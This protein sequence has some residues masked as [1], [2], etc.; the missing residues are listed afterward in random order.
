MFSFVVFTPCIY[1]L[2]CAEYTV[3]PKKTSL[4]GSKPGGILIVSINELTAQNL[5]TS[6]QVTSSFSYLLNS[7]HRKKCCW[8]LHHHKSSI[9]EF[10]TIHQTTNAGVASFDTSGYR[11]KMQLLSPSSVFGSVQNCSTRHNLQQTDG[12]NCTPCKG[13]VN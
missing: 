2:Y 9:N 3:C 7:L 1:I 13:C 5:I 11:H 6:E 12:K 8:D 4:P 10:V